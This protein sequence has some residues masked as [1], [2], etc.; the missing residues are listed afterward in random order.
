M[1]YLFLIAA[2]ILIS[3]IFFAYNSFRVS[4]PFIVI[5]ADNHFVGS[6][7][8]DGVSTSVDYDLCTSYIQ[9]QFRFA[10]SISRSPVA[11]SSSLALLSSER[12][13]AVS[14]LRSGAEY[15]LEVT[16][17]VLY[18]LDELLNINTR[19]EVM[20]SYYRRYVAPF[21]REVAFS[22]KD[23]SL[24]LQR[25][26]SDVPLSSLDVSFPYYLTLLNDAS[27]ILDDVY[28][29]F[30][31]TSVHGD[32]D[33]YREIVSRIEYYRSMVRGALVDLS[34]M[35]RD[36]AMLDARISSDQLSL[37]LVTDSFDNK[38]QQSYGTFLSSQRY[39]N[40]SSVYDYY[41]SVVAYIPADSFPSIVVGDS[42]YIDGY[43][44]Y[45][46]NVSYLVESALYEVFLVSEINLAPE[47]E[48]V[49]VF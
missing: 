41:T 17:S 10:E 37:L 36:F 5:P 44:F 21:N 33:I 28:A 22:L 4:N 6:V 1:R 34:E 30:Y 15:S 43:D 46:A 35:E 27:R 9:S 40:I 31:E 8:V 24:A 2:S 42:A 25:L 7:V 38:R 32:L 29:L 12:S 13:S 18:F 14:H 23:S 16:Q 39:C 49:V 45:V 3:G 20:S 47:Q 48:V 11:H 26:Y 19:G